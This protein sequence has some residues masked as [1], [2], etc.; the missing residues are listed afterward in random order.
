MAGKPRG[1]TCLV[2]LAAVAAA[3]AVAAAAASASDSF[4][5]DQPADAD[6]RFK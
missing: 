3:V 4:V 6:M 5:D 2:F 1:L